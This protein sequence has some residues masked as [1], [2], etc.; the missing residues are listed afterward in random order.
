METF[1]CGR[2]GSPSRGAAGFWIEDGAIAYPVQEVTIA[3]N[4]KDMFR[5][6]EAIGADLVV[7]GSRMSGSVLIREMTVAGD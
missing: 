4:L 1:V 7:R 2:S 3:S 5:C 6:I